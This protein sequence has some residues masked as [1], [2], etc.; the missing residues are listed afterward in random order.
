MSKKK[1]PLFVPAIMSPVQLLML[2]QGKRVNPPMRFPWVRFRRN[3]ESHG[4]SY[5]LSITVTD[6]NASERLAA[7]E[8]QGILFGAEARYQIALELMKFG[9]AEII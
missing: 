8:R 5:P 1:A 7:L 6:T 9:V 3:L 4:E 2:S